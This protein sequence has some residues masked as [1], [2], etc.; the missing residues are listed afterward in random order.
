MIAVVNWPQFW[1][2]RLW[3]AYHKSEIAGVRLFV[4]STAN[5]LIIKDISNTLP[6]LVLRASSLLSCL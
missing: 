6:A 5:S 3:F 2:Q 1:R 4:S